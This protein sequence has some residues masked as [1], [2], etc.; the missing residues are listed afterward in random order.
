M[1]IARLGAIARW[2]DSMALLFYWG[3]TKLSL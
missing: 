1:A 3:R 2:V